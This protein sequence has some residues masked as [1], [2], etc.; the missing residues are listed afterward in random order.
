M[1]CTCSVAPQWIEHAG[2]TPKS[3]H[4]KVYTPEWEIIVGLWQF[5]TEMNKNVPQIK[6]KGAKKCLHNEA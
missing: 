4:G 5:A 2:T 1:N 6:N 3:I